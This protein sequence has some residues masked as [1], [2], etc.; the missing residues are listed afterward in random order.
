MLEIDSLL[1]ASEVG[2]GQI[3]R[4]TQQFGDS[5]S[6]GG[7]NTFRKLTSGNSRISGSEAWES[8][9]PVLGQFASKTTRKFS[10]LLGMS[11]RVLGKESIPFGFS[12][13]TMGSTSTI[14]FVDLS[15]RVWG[16][17]VSDK[18]PVPF[19]SHALMWTC[20]SLGGIWISIDNTIPL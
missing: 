9:L 13:S 7:Q 14:K 6:Q 4:A 8:S 18:C 10:S 2:S 5:I 3:S 19:F 11:F 15:I 16:R 1:P 20:V 12:S 17:Y